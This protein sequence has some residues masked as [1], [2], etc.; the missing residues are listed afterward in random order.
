L[1]CVV[2]ASV[3]GNHQTKPR[4]LGEAIDGRLESACGNRSHLRAKGG[5]KDAKLTGSAMN[6]SEQEN[7]HKSTIRSPFFRA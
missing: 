7:I 4:R 5:R 1:F 2:D 3:G 6:I